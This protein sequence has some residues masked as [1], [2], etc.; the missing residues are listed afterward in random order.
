MTL[1]CVICHKT[2]DPANNPKKIGWV[3][4]QCLRGKDFETMSD[5]KLK[6]MIS[7]VTE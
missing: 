4:L 5:R 1:L 2:S 6:K 7:E 3:C